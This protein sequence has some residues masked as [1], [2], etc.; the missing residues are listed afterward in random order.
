MKL[1]IAGLVIIVVSILG[2]FASWHAVSLLSNHS[3]YYL[4][5]CYNP[6]TGIDHDYG[7]LFSYA[8]QITEARNMYG[9]IL[10]T[11]FFTWLFLFGVIFIKEKGNPPP[12]K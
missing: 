4:N 5:R 6:N 1:N 3:F 8:K 12:Q 11:V 10:V 9:K 7:A 2:F